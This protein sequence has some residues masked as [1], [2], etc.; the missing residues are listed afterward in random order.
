M[1]YASNLDKAL[2]AIEK[3]EQ[4]IKQLE[5]SG[6]KLPESYKRIPE[7]LK[8]IKN[9]PNRSGI[10]TDRLKS[11]QYLYNKN[12]INSRAKFDTT[13]TISRIGEKD[14]LDKR[15]TIKP[16]K[17]KKLQE[18]SK[19]LN[20]MLSDYL[21]KIDPVKYP[22]SIPT[23]QAKKLKADAEAFGIDLDDIDF[24]KL[25]EI[26]PESLR[27]AALIRDI[28]QV[29]SNAPSHISP[30]KDDI[31]KQIGE[32]N[33]AKF[34]SNMGFSQAEISLFNQYIDSSQFWNMIHKSHYSSSQETGK[35]EIRDVVKRLKAAMFDIE[36]D[37]ADFEQLQKLLKNGNN[38]RAVDNFVKKRLSKLYK[39]GK[40]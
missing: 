20:E 19:K 28:E 12:V 15:Q 35:H 27:H 23:I 14:I 37:R 22:M 31:Y 39:Q 13:M 26:G 29:F 16:N 11:I 36:S 1:S 10:S 25:A 33:H 21:D 40:M 38:Y 18:Y 5:A 6:F 2:R 30:F 32:E 17:P 3:N 9:D 7:E 8:A 24:T 34:L 4:Y